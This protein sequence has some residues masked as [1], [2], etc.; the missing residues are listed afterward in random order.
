MKFYAYILYSKKINKFIIASTDD[1]KKGLAE[2]NRSKS[3]IIR[4][5]FPWELVYTEEFDTRSEAFK[6][7]RF[8]KAQKSEKYIGNLIEKFRS[9][10]SENS[11]L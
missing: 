5:G 11:T 1:V 6:R 10:G 8:I 9:D 4:R 2:H 3:T 7:E